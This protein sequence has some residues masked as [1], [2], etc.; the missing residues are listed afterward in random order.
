VFLT[1]SYKLR[2][3][4]ILLAVLLPML[5]YGWGKYRAWKAEQ[6]RQ[7]VLRVID[8]MIIAAGNEELRPVISPVT[9]DQPPVRAPN[10]S[11]E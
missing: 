4:L 11:R 10:E 9:I 1:P 6:E 8:Q 3:L 7:R 2:T 5:W